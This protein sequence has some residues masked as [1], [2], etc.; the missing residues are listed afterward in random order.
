MTHALPYIDIA[1]CTIGGFD[2]LKN[3]EQWVGRQ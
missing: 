2:V 3:W 1:T